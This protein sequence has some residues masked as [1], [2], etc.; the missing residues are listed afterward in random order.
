MCLQTEISLPVIKKK[1]QNKNYYITERERFSDST[2]ISTASK[3]M[4]R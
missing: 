1:E 3:V 4:K 2:N